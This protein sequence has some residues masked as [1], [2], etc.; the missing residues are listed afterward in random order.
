MCGAEMYNL[1]ISAD[2]RR[3]RKLEKA[4]RDFFAKRETDHTEYY[5]AG[6]GNVP[7]ATRIL[8]HR[9]SGDALEVVEMC[10]KVLWEICGV[11]QKEGLDFTLQER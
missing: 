8:T 6:N 5:I 4:I 11:G 1:G 2:R 9:V 3:Q 10:R 7:D